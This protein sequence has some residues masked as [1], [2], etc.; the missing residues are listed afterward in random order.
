MLGALKPLF[1]FGA[2]GRV[3]NGNQWWSWVTLDDVVRAFIFAIDN[4]QTSGPYNV[5]APNPVTNAEFTK[6][7]A[8]VVRRP[9]VVPAP[10][11]A[12]RLVLRDMADEMLLCSQRIDTS[13]IQEAGFSCVD[14]ELEPALRGVL[15]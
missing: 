15:G 1:K 10:A 6:T 8:R 3:G 4:E 5:A 13:R 14:I 9:A 2:G 7:F 12:L 11:F